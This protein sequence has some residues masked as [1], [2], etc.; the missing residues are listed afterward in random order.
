MIGIRGKIEE[1]SIDLVYLMF[2]LLDIIDDIVV[3]NDGFVVFGDIN[4]VIIIKEDLGFN[5]KVM[6]FYGYEE[7][8][9]LYGIVIDNNG[10]IFVNDMSSGNIYILLDGGYFLKKIDID[11]L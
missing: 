1:Y 4:K 5:Y 10:F 2:W 3:D 7:L 8:V 6:F 9:G 11:L